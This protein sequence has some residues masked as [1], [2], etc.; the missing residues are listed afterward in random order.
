MTGLSASES[1]LTREAE[2]QAYGSSSFQHRF[3]IQVVSSS[4]HR[5][6]WIKETDL[7]KLRVSIVCLGFVLLKLYSNSAPCKRERVATHP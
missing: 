2:S 7:F 3:L 1:P 6:C 4:S 5:V